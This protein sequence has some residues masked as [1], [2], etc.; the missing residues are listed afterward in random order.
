MLLYNVFKIS[1]LSCI[2][3]SSVALSDKITHKTLDNGLNILVKEDH[4]YPV[5]NITFSYNVG[6]IN[7]PAFQTGISHFLE[8]VMYGRTNNLSHT[9][10][11]DYYNQHSAHYSATTSHESTSYTTMVLPSEISSVLQFEKDRLTGLQFLPEDI[12]KE[13]NAILQEKKQHL[14]VTPWLEPKELLNTH[15]FPTGVYHHPVIGW[16]SDIES[17]SYLEIK[18]WYEKWY[19]P[20]N[21]TI[22]VVGDVSTDNIVSNIKL[23]FDEIPSHPLKRKIILENKKREGDIRVD[24][25][26]PVNNPLYIISF[27]V[28]KPDNSS[29]ETEIILTLL[30]DLLTNPQ[31]GIVSQ[32]LITNNHLAVDVDSELDYLKKTNGYFSFYITPN[33][34]IHFYSIKNKLLSLMNNISEA[35]ISDHR[36]KE[37]K[38]RYLAQHTFFQDSIADQTRIYSKLISLD[39]L[40]NRYE[41]IEEALEHITKKQIAD[42]VK[43][44]FNEDSPKA[45]LTI[46]PL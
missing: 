38:Q 6:S 22:I 31:Q 14:T 39:L 2:C 17:I 15:A 35:D 18:N 27:Q 1:L 44:H 21:L 30:T 32:E 23:L 10:I 12:E 29:L 42:A 8:H 16:E 45:I 41:T 28:P 26:R 24:I 11:E 9:N 25:K 33:K 43:A 36:L 20:N 37:V 19:N 34:N 7:E 40:H 13:R 3:L 46:K 4:R 5:A